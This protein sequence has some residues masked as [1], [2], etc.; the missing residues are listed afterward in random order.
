MVL[1]QKSSNTLNLLKERKSDI[2]ILVFFP[3]N[4]NSKKVNKASVWLV[5]V[6]S[7]FPL[8]KEGYLNLAYIFNEKYVN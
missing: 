7:I 2:Q 4:R 5:E 8:T 6:I 1:F 3:Y